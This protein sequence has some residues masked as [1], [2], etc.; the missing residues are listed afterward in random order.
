[1]QIDVTAVFQFAYQYQVMFKNNTGFSH[2]LL[3]S[4]FANPIPLAVA[5]AGL[6]SWGA[7]TIKRAPLL[8]RFMPA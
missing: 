8:T 4:L 6:L 5:C 2:G 3:R 7:H 1:M